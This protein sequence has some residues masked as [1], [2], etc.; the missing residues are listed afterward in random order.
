M[1]CP[2]CGREMEAG[3]IRGGAPYLT[4][5]DRKRISIFGGN[6]LEG[7]S[8]LWGAHL[9]A[10]R[11]LGCELIMAKKVSRYDK[12]S[13]ESTSGSSATCEKRSDQV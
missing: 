6:I 11:C 5:T 12:V 9:P 1:N 7:S 8:F 10:F 2:Y 13:E 3:Y 4:W